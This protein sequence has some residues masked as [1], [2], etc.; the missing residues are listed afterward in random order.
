MGRLP[1]HGLPNGA[2]STPG[3]RTSEPR[4][5]EVE[6]ENLTAMPLG[7]P[8]HVAFKLIV[9]ETDASELQAQNPR[10]T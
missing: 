1:Q 6:R 8:Q 7:Q 3:I 5:A 9:V 2:M 4:A 10:K